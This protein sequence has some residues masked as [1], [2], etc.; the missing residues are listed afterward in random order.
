M[1][2]EHITRELQQDLAILRADLGT[3]MTQVK[4]LGVAQSREMYDKTR[5]Q[6]RAAQDSLEHH[7]E[8]RPLSSVLFAFGTGFAI[9][10]LIGNR[11]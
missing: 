6:V 5:Q 8:L 9:G 1:A 10:R 2:T 3:L 11:R 7:I 4:A